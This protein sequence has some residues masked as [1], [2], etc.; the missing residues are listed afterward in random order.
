M[1]NIR[2]SARLARPIATLAFLSS[3]LLL[4]ACGSDDSTS[5]TAGKAAPAKP[6]SASGAADASVLTKLYAGDY[7]APPTTGPTAQKGKKVWFVS[8]GQAF[9]A[10]AQ[11]SSSFKSAGQK[12]GW[13]VNVVDGKA[14]PATAGNLIKQAVA[15]KADGIAWVAFDCPGIKAALQT[16]KSAGIPT[17]SWGSLDCNDATL[18]GKG[19]QL[20]KVSL[21]PRGGAGYTTWVVDYTKARADA[22]LA[23]MKKPGK[24]LNLEEQ[25]QSVHKTFTKVFKGEIAAKCPTCQV[26]SVKYSFAQPPSTWVQ[27]FK[28]AILQNP[29]AKAISNDTDALMSLGLA[30][31]VAQSGEKD[32]FIM[33]AEGA[34]SNLDLIRKGVQGAALNVSGFEWQMWGMADALNRT[35]AGQ[36]KL[37]PEGGGWNLIDKDHNLPSSPGSAVAPAT[38]YQAAYGKIWAGQ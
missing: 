23:Y 15:A 36:A 8:C 31:A 17:A 1:V 16:A 19:P 12:L 38:D 34:P 35:F 10:C 26:V 6:A 21:N 32:L 2:G 27:A 11:M 33:G 29:D 13:S 5:A 3:A 20:I 18:G 4:A 9:E 24:I 37:P 30:T 25:S 14:N 7:T 22:L 28:G